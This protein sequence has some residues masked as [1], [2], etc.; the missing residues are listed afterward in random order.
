MVELFSHGGGLGLG[1]LSAGGLDL[2]A[3]DRAPGPLAEF[4]A[5]YAGRLGAGCC[6]VPVPFGILGPGPGSGEFLTEL[7]QVSLGLLMRRFGGGA[8]LGQFRYQLFP[9]PFLRGRL[10]PGFLE[11]GLPNGV[12]RPPATASA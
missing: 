1:A 11:S 6:L 5:G 9:R 4:G 2:C 10:F 3:G 12:D 8:G 7:S